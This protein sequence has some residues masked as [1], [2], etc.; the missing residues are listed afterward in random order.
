MIG[1][2]FVL[3]IICSIADVRGIHFNGGTITWFP[4]DPY[5]NG[6]LVIVTIVQAYT[7]TLSTVNCDINVPITTPARINENNNLTCVG[8]CSNQGNY[9]NSMIDILTDCISTSPPINLMKSQKAKNVTLQID[10]SF[11]I[12]YRDSSWRSLANSAGVYWS[13]VS[14]I[15]LRRRPDGILNSSPISNVQ[16]PQYVIVN[17]TTKIKVPTF[18]VNL[19]DDVRCRWA[20]K[21]G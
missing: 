5:T 9:T 15:D 8:N 21:L 18:D 7:W 2:L 13:I 19:K 6:S 1:L 17:Q 20:N 11:S 10:S 4:V 14:H 12:A 3:V 16:S